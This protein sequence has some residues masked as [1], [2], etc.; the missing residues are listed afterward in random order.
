MFNFSSSEH[1]KKAD[2]MPGGGAAGAGAGDISG[3]RQR[4][5]HPSEDRVKG[6]EGQI[7]SPAMIHRDEQGIPPPAPGVRNDSP[8]G[9]G[10]RPVEGQQPKESHERIEGPREGAPVV[11][12]HELEADGAQRAGD[13]QVEDHEL[14]GNVKDGDVHQQDR[15]GGES[16][17]KVGHARLFLL[18]DEPPGAVQAYVDKL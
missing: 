18:K 15:P 14:R 9:E 8:P 6:V 1:P 12:G 3:P 5:E 4:E 13:D 2:G 7:G 11:K 10:Y 17:D 16:Q